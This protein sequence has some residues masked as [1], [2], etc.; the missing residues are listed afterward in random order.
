[1][2]CFFEPGKLQTARELI[3]LG[4]QRCPKSED[5]WLEAA[6]LEKPRNAKAVLAKA[7]SVLPH[8]VGEAFG[9]PC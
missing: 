2:C 1:M 7:V 3:S 5:V 8:S 9:S 6:R 4:C